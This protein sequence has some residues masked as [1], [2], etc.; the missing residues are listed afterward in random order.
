MLIS[1]WLSHDISS[2]CD[3]TLPLS[4]WLVDNIEMDDAERRLAVHAVR[5][6]CPF[7]GGGGA[8]GK[9]AIAP[10]DAAYERELSAAE[11]GHKV[12]R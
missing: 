3:A 1:L 7:F 5:Q 10:V 6:G 8:A 12:V 9:W 11:R 2:A 4:E